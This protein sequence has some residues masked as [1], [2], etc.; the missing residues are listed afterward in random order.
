VR[1]SG[2][3]CLRPA[4]ALLAALLL[5]A[6]PAVLPSARARAADAGTAP[7]PGEVV[8]EGGSQVVHPPPEPQPAEPLHADPFGAGART[9]ISREAF[10]DT[11]RT[12]ADV[13][14]DVPGVTVTRSGD[15]LSASRVSIRGSR[16]EQVLILLDGVPLNPETD[17]PAQRRTQSRSGLDLAAL[18]LERV[19]SIEIVRGAASSLY[20][21]GA[22]AGA[23]L[24]RTR[25]A[26]EP[27]L[28]AAATAG[29]D[30]YREADAAWTLPVGGAAPGVGPGADAGGSLTLHAN[31]RRS[32]G[33]YVFFDA[34]A[35]NATTA[36]PA[37]NPCA[38]PLGGGLFRRGCNAT[39]TTTLDAD[40]RQGP[41]LHGAALL[42]R[43]DRHGLGGI[44]DPRPFG[45]ERRDRARL[46]YEDA[47]AGAPED[48][49]APLLSWQLAA[50]QLRVD[51]NDNPGLADAALLSG[52]TDRHGHGELRWARWL[53]R[54]RVEL[55]AA[56]EREVLDDRRFEAA[57]STGSLFA[58]WDYHPAGGTWEASLR[59]D[60][61]SDQPGRATGRAAFSSALAGG[62][63][64]KGSAATGYR[65]PTLYELYDPGSSAGTSVANPGLQPELSTSRDGGV[66][67]ARE[68][69]LYGELLAFRQDTR[70]QIVALPAPA[71]PNLFRFENVNRTRSTGLEASLET[72]GLAGLPG[73]QGL[74]TSLTWTQ[75]RAE[76]LDN[77][78]IDPR[79]NGHLVPGVPE[80]RGAASLAWRGGGWHL[81]LQARHSGRRF[82]DTANT[83]YLQ[84][85]TVVD[86]GLTVP[87]GAGWSASL[88]GRNLGNVT[89]AELDN[90]PPPGLQVFFTLRWQRGEPQ[91]K[92]EGA[93][94]GPS[95]PGLG[96]AGP[97]GTPT[98][99]PGA[100]SGAPAGAA[101]GALR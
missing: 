5:V 7:P 91:R 24:I 89:Y 37:V 80:R 92:P 72:R 77:D 13:L 78:A 55:G 67:Y 39:R 19:E 50:E 35:A 65:P 36:L 3:A 27:A 40:W 41:H 61:L 46:L 93:A 47:H 95:G 57:R 99:P 4:A 32:D 15:G 31:H 34:D 76:I 9:V 23:I 49:A 12:V 8:V 58:A 21:P 44:E 53:Q 69:A 42:E 56:A 71:S 11:Q 29:S 87:L 62:F 51:R 94:A 81:W 18:P 97:P 43:L 54:H 68:E 2:D 60:A 79:D 90:F 25:R 30:G 85:Y 10:R 70:Q 1:C 96:P 82:V 16:P 88:E 63:G 86:A 38:T 17:N 52:Y 59:Q 75:Q 101:P 48:P 66:Y 83:R 14:D 26:P 22:A 100:G 64:L 98:L 33:S 20:G 28:S 6:L 73:W 45:I 84:A 74:A